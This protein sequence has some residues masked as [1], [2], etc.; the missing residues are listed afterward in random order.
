MG[1]DFLYAIRPI[2]DLYGYCPANARILAEVKLSAPRRGATCSAEVDASATK[3]ESVAKPS[4]TTPKPP[5]FALRATP[6][7]PFASSPRQAAGILA[8]ASEA[9]PDYYLFV[10]T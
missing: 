1:A 6:W 4:G 10:A 8:K 2:G 9:K 3:V 7:S 5:G